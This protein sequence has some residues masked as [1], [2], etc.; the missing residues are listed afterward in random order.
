MNKKKPT[1]LL[2]LNVVYL[3]TFLACVALVLRLGYVQIASGPMFRAYENTIHLTTLPV[4]P[5]RGLIYDAN[6]N[7][8][9]YNK[10]VI[11]INLMKVSTDTSTNY[12]AL[13]NQLAPVLNM[14]PAALLTEMNGGGAGALEVP[15]VKSATPDE[16]TYV[17]EHHSDFPDLHIEETLQRVYPYG[18]LAGQVLG[19]VGG[20]PSQS[21]A[22]YSARKYINQ[23]IVG[24][25]GL[26]NQY[27]QYLQGKPGKQV[28]AVS[29]QGYPISY[30]GISPAP[31]PGK[32]IQ[33]SLDGRIQALTQ[34]EIMNVVTKSPYANYITDAE[35]VMLNVK[36]GGV[37]TLVSYPY[38]DPNWYESTVEYN[39]H[40]N[41]LENS[42]AQ[43][44]NAIQSPRYPGSTVK[45][46]NLITGLENGII[47]LGM[48]FYDGYS[49][50]VGNLSK[51]NDD[52]SFGWINPIQAIQYSSDNFFY[53][54]GLWLG[55]WVGASQT[56]PGHQVS[57]SFSQWLHTDYVKG[58]DKLYE[59]EMRFGL[60]MLTG[61]DLPS[62]VQGRFYI[63][64]TSQSGAPAVPY[65]VSQAVASIKK[66]GQYITNGTPAD[67]ADAG[68]GQ[69]QEFTP[70]ELAQ[71]VSTL[72][73]NGLKLQPHLL[74]KV[75][76]AN[77][78][79]PNQTKPLKLEGAIVQS[80]LK[81]NQK[82]FNAAHQGMYDV[83]NLP[84]GTAYGV[85]TG[86]PYTVAGKTGTAQI[87]SKGM[88][89]D[90]SV[91]ICY[92]PYN[93]PQVA[94]AVMIPGAG[95][96]ATGAAIV[97]RQMLDDY[98]KEHHEFFPKSQWTGTE[99]PSNW[100]SMSAYTVPENMK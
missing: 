99:I 8:L 69:M 81:I 74:E 24:I 22:Y 62:E 14:K 76:P 20:I 19:Y 67:L 1:K 86:A 65:N 97:A 92:A 42:Y 47:H 95:Y 56:S 35:A 3:I 73:D 31:V 33:I 13:A 78:T 34:Q 9:A 2:R 87:P 68:I 82:W 45:P 63:K 57:G 27:E 4:L 18:D 23:Q 94:V 36:T 12:Q 83:V 5:P 54:V 32:D 10:P 79:S 43:L 25:T 26:E 21:A 39:D 29:A 80:H 75:L 37:I 28:A 71:Y 64:D 30:L 100:T 90:N 77:T 44:D 93:N 49:T 11:S 59:G 50:M 96:G 61:I 91:F 88:N 53:E 85:F 16:I 48:S 40:F 46:S 15:L 6:G 72:A 70:I 58:I 98:F 60:G 51:S 7:L 55:G 89:L 17:E 66:T 38:L 84:G 52:S 41:Y